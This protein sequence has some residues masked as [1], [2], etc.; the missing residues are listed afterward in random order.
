MNKLKY[1]IKK[2]DILDFFI[3]FQIDQNTE[4][5][6]LLGGFTSKYIIRLYLIKEKT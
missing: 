4:Y 3:T 1:L 2:C 6:S 5:K